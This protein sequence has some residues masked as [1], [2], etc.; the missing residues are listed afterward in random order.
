VLGEQARREFDP[1]L[2]QRRKEHWDELAGIATQI[3]SFWTKYSESPRMVDKH[4]G[5][6]MEEYIIDDPEFELI[7][8]FLADGL[9]R[10]LKAEFPDEFKTVTKHKELIKNTLPV[11]CLRG[12]AL[13]A[14]RKTFEGTCPVC[15]SSSITSKL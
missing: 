11:E 14:H 3:L 9:L 7:D 8:N 13:L 2:V 10:H 6:Y 12:L 5:K 15:P 1:V 4:T